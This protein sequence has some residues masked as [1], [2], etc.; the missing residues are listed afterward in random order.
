VEIVLFVLCRRRHGPGHACG[1]LLPGYP[2]QWVFTGNHFFGGC[3][4]NLLKHL[5]W[6]ET[7]APEKLSRGT[8]KYR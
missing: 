3:P 7:V 8:E 2:V 4:E 5:T 6:N 1:W